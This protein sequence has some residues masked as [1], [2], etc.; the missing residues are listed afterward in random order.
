MGKL[1]PCLIG[2]ATLQLMVMDWRL[3]RSGAN[4][5]PWHMALDEALWKSFP[6]IGKPT[7]RFYRWHEPTLSIGYSQR[8]ADFDLAACGRLGIA[9]VRRPT[10]GGAVL[11]DQEVTYSFVH[12]LAGLGGLRESH[13]LIAEAL[14][15]GLKSLGLTAELAEARRGPGLRSSGACFA[16]PSYA[17][18]TAAG[19]KVAG[20]AQ[21]RD[22]STLLEQGSIPLRLNLERL[23]TVIRSAGLSKAELISLL[24]RRAAG[25]QDFVAVQVEDVERALVAGFAARFG[26]AFV[27]SWPTAEELASAEELMERKY[28]NPSWSFRR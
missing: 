8:A 4:V 22:R 18:L 26:A 6:Q 14:A 1:S 15:L 28:A 5:G 16:S 19:R 24:R 10:G 11:H 21:V 7:L 9:F 25:L 23:A 20:A 17:E 2:S 13:R 3:L 27:E 12:P